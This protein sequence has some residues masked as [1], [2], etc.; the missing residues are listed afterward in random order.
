MS[1]LVD[2]RLIAWHMS[3]NFVT[4]CVGPSNY[5]NTSRRIYRSTFGQLKNKLTGILQNATLVKL[6]LHKKIIGTYM[7]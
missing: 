1:F 6:W 5:L 3:Y 2:S 7:R 4:F